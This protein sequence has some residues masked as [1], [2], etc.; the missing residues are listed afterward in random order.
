[1]RKERTFVLNASCTFG[2]GAVERKQKSRLFHK[3]THFIRLF[4][5]HF[6]IFAFYFR[7]LLENEL[8]VIPLVPLCNLLAAEDWFTLCLCQVSDHAMCQLVV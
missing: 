5:Q 6:C 7:N 3:Q 1:M 4:L 2:N 8:N